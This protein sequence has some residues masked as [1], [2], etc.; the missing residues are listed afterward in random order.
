MHDKKS[1]REQ[2]LASANLRFLKLDA[3]VGIPIFPLTTQKHPF[4]YLNDNLVGF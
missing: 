3:N 2:R 1:K 4:Y